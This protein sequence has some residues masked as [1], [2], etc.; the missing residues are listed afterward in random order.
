MKIEDPGGEFST[1]FGVYVEEDSFTGH[2]SEFLLPGLGEKT[3]VQ[4][5]LLFFG[6]GI[7]LF[8]LGFKLE[9]LRVFLLSYVFLIG[10]GFLKRM[11]DYYRARKCKKCGKEFAY[12]EARSPEV[13][14]YGHDSRVETTSYYR[15]RFC[16][17]EYVEVIG[18]KKIKR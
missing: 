9:K 8:I 15:C 3:V 1:G 6:V 10:G 2:A 14:E 17:H 11:T 7:F 18:Q 16:G 13:E 4:I 12:L 5:Y